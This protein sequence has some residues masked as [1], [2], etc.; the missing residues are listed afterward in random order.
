[1]VT[2][3]GAYNWNFIKTWT[4]DN[5]LTC[6]VRWIHWDLNPNGSNTRDLSWFLYF[7]VS[8][9]VSL[10]LEKLVF[11]FFF[12]QTH[13]LQIEVRWS[14]SIFNFYA[15]SCAIWSPTLSYGTNS[16]VYQ[17][18]IYFFIIMAQFLLKT[19]FYVI[20]ISF[21]KTHFTCIWVN[22]RRFKMIIIS[23]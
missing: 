14:T 21:D 12:F 4:H 18:F 10:D 17:F 8:L 13:Y 20:G 15:V 6:L 1:M 7:E 22:L 16:G 19:H 3:Y 23:G 9:L 5:Y 11:F 2:S